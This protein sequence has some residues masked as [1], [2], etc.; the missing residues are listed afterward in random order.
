MTTEPDRYLRVDKVLE[1][2]GFSR[3]TLYR[4]VSEGTFPRQVQLSSRCIGWRLSDVERW[5]TH[6]TSFSA[7]NM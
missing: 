4:K 5:A 2:T 7:A 6:P 3:S 1:L